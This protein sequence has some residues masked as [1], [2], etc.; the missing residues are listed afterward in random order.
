MRDIPPEKLKEFGVISDP[1]PI[2]E[3]ERIGSRL[4]NPL[5][6]YDTVGNVKEMVAAASDSL[7]AFRGASF[8]HNPGE[9]DIGRHDEITAINERGAERTVSDLGLRLAFSTS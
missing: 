5:G 7:I 6:L 8:K 2:H 9:V 4:P 1:I 3:P